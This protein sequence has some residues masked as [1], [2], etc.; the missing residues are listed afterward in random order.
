MSA[1]TPGPWEAN[2]HGDHWQIDAAMDAVATTHFCYAQEREANARLIA[3]APDMLAA[4]KAALAIAPVN[5]DDGDDPE[6]SEAWAAV[7]GAIAK[8]EGRTP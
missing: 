8:A 2:R 7:R 5:A 3:A 1:Y 4:L 6:Q